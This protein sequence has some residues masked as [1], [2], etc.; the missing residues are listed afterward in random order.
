M[1]GVFGVKE[2]RMQ[3]PPSHSAGSGHAH[4]SLFFIFSLSPLQEDDAKE[5][6]LS[7]LHVLGPERRKKMKPL[8]AGD[9]D[10]AKQPCAAIVSSRPAVMAVCREECEGAATQR[11]SGVIVLGA[12]RRP[13]NVN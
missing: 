1:W 12:F 8:F 4:S 2:R 3:E 9:T 11:Q 13:E 7:A 10:N 5:R 6:L